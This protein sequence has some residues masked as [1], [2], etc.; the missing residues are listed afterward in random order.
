MHAR[1]SCKCSKAS[2]SCNLCN[3]PMPGAIIIAT[4]RGATDED[5]QR[6]I[7]MTA[8]LERRADKGRP[9]SGPTS[10]SATPCHLATPKSGEVVPHGGPS[11]QGCQDCLRGLRT[12]QHSATSSVRKQQEKVD[13][14]RHPQPHHCSKWPPPTAGR[15]AGPQS[16]CGDPRVCGARGHLFLR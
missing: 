14:S 7:Y 6:G 13:Q 10:L 3:H 11:S 2:F 15:A 8:E 1:N 5:A 4:L 12:A 16:P 9:T